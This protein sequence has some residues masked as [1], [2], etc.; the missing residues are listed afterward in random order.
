MYH[1]FLSRTKRGS[2]R[3]DYSVE[4]MNNAFVVFCIS[5]VEFVWV[6][7]RVHHR[8]MGNDR[9]VKALARALSLNTSDVI[10]TTSQEPAEIRSI[11]HII[12]SQE[13]HSRD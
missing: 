10:Y 6:N 5:N 12:A 1:Y 9:E 4:V 2:L 8:E 13:N 11:F 3:V 7:L